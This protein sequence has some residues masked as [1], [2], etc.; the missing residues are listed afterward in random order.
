MVRAPVHSSS[1]S[2]SGTKCNP[3]GYQPIA[4]T[5]LCLSNLLGAPPPYFSEHGWN[6]VTIATA[7]RAFV[8]SIASGRLLLMHVFPWYHYTNH[9][10]HD[11]APLSYTVTIISRML[12]T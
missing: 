8:A 9:M 4:A 10:D 6:S 3:A 11:I 1:S 7:T 5:D 2:C 12:G